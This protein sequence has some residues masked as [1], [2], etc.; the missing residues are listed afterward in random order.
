MRK[1][2]LLV[3]AA[4]LGA[5]IAAPIAVYAS[6]R[7][8]DVPDSH[9]FHNAIDWMAD[10]NITVGCNPPANDRYCPDEYVTRAQMAAFMKRLAESRVVDAG[11]AA[12]LDGWARIAFLHSNQI[13][14]R[15][16]GG[17]WQETGGGP[18][19]ESHAVTKTVY[20][21]NGSAEMA[22]AAPSAIG[23]TTYEL[24]ALRL[25]LDTPTTGGFVTAFQ[26][27]VM[28][29]NGSSGIPMSDST[30]LTAKGCYDYFR[31]SGINVGEGLT[32]VAQLDGNGTVQ[33]GSVTAVW[34]GS[35]T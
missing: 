15:H 5:L 6:H 27:H 14:T 32:V 2:A 24:I 31:A 19:A 18:L 22:L 16:P 8:N 1:Y 30:D 9:T 10:N 29:Q 12:S 23:R 35:T 11:D 28:D 3:A 26:V 4:V 21:G 33:L 17:L 13:T 7:F 34:S 25:C 20:I